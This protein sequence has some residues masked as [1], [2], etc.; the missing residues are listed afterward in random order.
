[1]DLLKRN[2][3]PILPDAWKLID[4]EAARVL[5]LLLAGRK[6]VDFKG[7]SGWAY[8]AVNTGKLKILNAE[9]AASVGMGIREVQPLVEVRVPIKLAIMDLDT[10]ARGAEDPD[11]Q[12]VV[13]AAEKIALV[14]DNAIFNGLPSAGIKGILEASPHP[15]CPLPPNVL[16]LPKAIL[17][18]REILRRAGVDGPYVLVLGAAL[19]EQVLAATD[20]GH[21]LAKRIEQQIVDRPIVRAEAVKGAALLS[22]RGGDYELHVGQDLSIGYAYHSKDEVEL[23]LTESFTFRVLEPAAA[24]RITNSAK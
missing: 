12:A 20:E 6:I 24:V 3:A 5:R 1:V 13:T 7:P 19:H 9:P 22:L 18:A 15:T 11:L 8:A 17:D 14:E 16:D 23:Y 4:A 10:V 21:S 2:L